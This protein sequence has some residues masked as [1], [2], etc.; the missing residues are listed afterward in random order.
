[1]RWGGYEGFY[2]PSPLL[3]KEGKGGAGMKAK[4]ANAPSPYPLPVG[5]GKKRQRDWIPDRGRE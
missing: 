3:T 5:E 4:I 1:M 2:L